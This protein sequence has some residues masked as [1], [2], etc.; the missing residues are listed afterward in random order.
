MS[1]LPI[2]DHSY[3]CYLNRGKLMGVR[4]ASCGKFFVPPQAVCSACN[5]TALSWTPAKGTG[6][7]VAFTCIAVGPASMVAEGFGPDNPYCTGVIELDEKTRV[8]ARIEGVDAQNPES[9]KIGLPLQ[10]VFQPRG[11]RD[12]R[13]AILIFKPRKVDAVVESP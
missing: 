1:E 5:G 6:K 7:L 12:D 13:E 11:D 3:Q 8:V 4:C 9:I 10:A 2:S